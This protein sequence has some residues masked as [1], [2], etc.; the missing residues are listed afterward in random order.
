MHTPFK[1]VDNLLSILQIIG[2]AGLLIYNFH[3]HFASDIGTYQLFLPPTTNAIQEHLNDISI[4]TES[5][6]M[7][8]NESKCSYM[9][10]TRAQ[11]EFATGL[12]VNER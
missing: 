10:F 2:L 11:A 6:L 12:T 4:W 7:K 9:I 8:I 1:Y 3:S 5:N